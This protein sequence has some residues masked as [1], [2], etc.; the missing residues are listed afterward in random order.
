MVVRIIKKD[1]DVVTAADLIEDVKKSNKV[2]EA[3]AIF[4]FEGIVRGKEPGKKVDKLILKTPDIEKA[5]KEMKEIAEDVKTKFGVFEVNI[6][7]YIGEFYTGDSLFIVAILGPHR[8]KSYEA[9]IDT[10]ERVKFD[11]DFEK[12]EI[13]NQGSKTILAGG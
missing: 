10:I 5:E 3:G 9:L 1:D 12:E 11:I 2:D 4:T 8:Q 13:S 7:H 6:I